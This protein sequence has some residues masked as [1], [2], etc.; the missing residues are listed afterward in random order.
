MIEPLLIALAFTTGLV[1]KRLGMPPLLGYLLAGFAA[2]EFGLGD[3]ALINSIAD[4][5]IILLLF[6]IGLK[7]NAS[8]LLSPHI[9][10]VASLHTAV[11]VPTI[12]VV[13]FFIPALTTAL[14]EVST[15]SAAVLALALSFSS[16]VFAVKIFEDRGEGASLHAQVAIGILIVQDI[17]AVA[18]LLFSAR[19]FPSAWAVAILLAL[20]LLRLLLVRI[21]RLAGHGELL[22]LFG[23]TVALCSAQLFELVNLKGGLGALIF[24]VLLSRHSKSVELYKSLMGFKDIFLTAFFLSVGYYG[25]PSGAMLLVALVLTV[26]I[27]MR[28]L[29]Y[30][31]LMLLFRLRARTAFLA[32]LS[33]INYS[34]FGLIVAAIAVQSGALSSQWLTTLAVAMALS[35]FVA[36]P[37]NAY[38]H[39]WYIRYAGYFQRFERKVLIAEERSV[40]LGEAD[41]LVFGMGRIG[42]G[43]YEYLTKENVQQII[44]VDESSEKVY[45]LQAEGLRCVHGDVSDGEFLRR[46][47]LQRR[48]LILVSLS[49]HEENVDV[50]TLLR[51]LDYAGRISVICRFPDQARELQDMGCTTFNLYAEAGHGFAERALETIGSS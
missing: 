35:L 32:S 27:V 13:L 12:A 37:V 7:L 39:R 38:A 25:L 6:T 8:D 40:D 19:E 5:A 47:H 9:W 15:S 10:A 28:P 18:Y 30:F 31:P 29:I 42:K 24:G 26:F 14:P 44:G 50:V 22:I 34:E 41:V 36:A 17:F 49:K 48:K 1:F 4:F 46:A 23:I 51:Q 43:A 45:K 16:T 3:A 11:V 2:A 21:L 20:P 33:L